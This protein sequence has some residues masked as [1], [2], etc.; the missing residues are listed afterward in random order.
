MLGL[1][2]LSGCPD[3]GDGGVGG[4]SGPLLDAID[5][6]LPV[7]FVEQAYDEAMLATLGTAPYTW[8]VPEWQELPGGLSVTPDGRL[9]GVPS[10][11]GTFT[12]QVEVVDA[13]GRQKRPWV[14]LNVV[15]EPHILACGDTASG[16]FT[17][18]GYGG[19]DPDFD[20][21]GGYEW[22]A[23]SLPDDE[24]TRIQLVFTLDRAVTAYVGKPSEVIGSWDVEE[25][26]ELRVLDPITG[27]LTVT[28]DPST[29]PSLSGFSNQELLSVLAVAQAAGDWE[30]E[31]VCSDGPVFV[32]VPQYPTELGQEIQI[33][34]EVYDEPGA[35]IY[36]NDELPEWVIWDEAT[37]VVSGTAEEVGSWPITVVAEAPDGRTREERSII[38]VYE[39]E[40][41]QCGE[42][43]EGST[44]EGYFDGEFT[45]YYD[46][47]GYRV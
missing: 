28:V 35:R 31:V 38:G 37:G 1:L 32:V 7:A 24:T 12:F 41:V 10:Q 19:S 34:F 26:Y 16:T 40:D 11:A 8:S 13:A 29:D 18:S 15:L 45:S 43:V 5:Q 21:F 46:P 14:S 36:T 47:N 33:D 17:A 2:V 23:V 20:K 42:V 9:V 4:S 27:N 44:L 25:H 39:V 22:L 30:V 6:T 3:K